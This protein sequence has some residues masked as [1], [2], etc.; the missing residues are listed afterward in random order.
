MIA[1]ANSIRIPLRDESCQTV[2][3]SPPYWGLRVYKGVEAT[4]WGGVAACV[5]E[6]REEQFARGQTGGVSGIE[7]ARPNSLLKR[8]FKKASAGQFCRLCNAWRGCLGLEPTPELYVKHL[9]RIFRE[10]RRVLRRD[11]TVW[12]NLGDSY[13]SPGKGGPWDAG[14]TQSTSKNASADAHQYA[15]QSNRGVLP[16]LKP[17]DLCG[18]P[19]RVAL[20]LQADG[21][22]LRS[23]II[24][25]KPNP[26]PESV[27]DRPTRSHE[28]VFLLTKAARYA[29][30]ADAVRESVSGT[31]HRRH[32]MGGEPSLAFKM[33]EPGSGNRNNPSFQSYMRDLPPELGRNCR[34]VWTI[35]TRGYSG[36]HFATFPPALVTPCILAGGPSR[37]CPVCGAG[38][39]RVVERHRRTESTHHCPKH[40]QGKASGLAYPG[41]RKAETPN[42]YSET[43]GW[44]PTC[45]H[46]AEPTGAIVLDPFCGTAT[47]GAVCR[48]LGRRFIGL[49][50][51]GQ[52]LRELALPRAEKKNTQAALM[53]LPLFAEAKQ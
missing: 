24:W 27:T 42:A 53:E 40:L 49:D 45:N 28:Y 12:L 5:H 36:A 26:M 44:Q 6:W 33:E 9:M 10:V 43:T 7:V 15:K 23:E 37:S 8:R 35:S 50:L 11:G 14:R 17:K 4:V 13:A 41:W 1:Q 46:D 38:W 32:A 3:T 31:A 25:H 2:V 16:G 18:I 52:Y 30:D 20:A 21:W 47:V 48:E 39:R 19:W 22:W 34:T 29:Y 51:S